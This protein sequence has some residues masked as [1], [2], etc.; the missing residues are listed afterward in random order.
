MIK[1]LWL[2]GI[3]AGS[4]SHMTLD[5]VDALRDVAI[6]LMPHKGD[7]KGD[8]VAVRQ[9]IIQASGS[10]AKIVPFDYPKRDPS[11]PYQE[12]VSKWHDEI[13]ECW[14]KV[15]RQ[16]PTGSIGGPVGLL[17]WGDPSLYDSTLRIAQRL[18]PPP[19]IR[20]IPGITALQALTAA[21]CIPFNTVGGSVQVTT[22]R[23][24]SK[25]GWPEGAETVAVMLDGTAQFTALAENDVHVWWGAYLG[26]PYQI[27]IA[28]PLREV[29]PKI[30]KQ[31]AAAR[32]RHGWIMDCC[33]LQR[34]V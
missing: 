1:D 33:L 27:L 16:L 5:G 15:L 28:G 14:I 8:L 3:G 10:K 21:H 12:R 30:Q 29:G 18:T 34:D 13:A 23:Q 25:S 32:E 24:L 17:V 26:M 19:N 20:V 6:I 4:P 11:L 9:E 31:R 2:I 22:G 7:D